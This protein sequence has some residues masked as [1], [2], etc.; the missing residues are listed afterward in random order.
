M[1]IPE[2]LLHHPQVTLGALQLYGKLRALGCD[3]SPRDVPIKA[4]GL[5]RRE[6]INKSRAVLIRI[7][8]LEFSAKHG[9]AGKYLLTM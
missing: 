4:L 6:Y 2:R 7:G 8:A 1:E 5:Q 9:H 3:V